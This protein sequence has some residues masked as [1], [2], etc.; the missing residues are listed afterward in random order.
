MKLLLEEISI[1]RINNIQ[2]GSIASRWKEFRYLSF[3]NNT[4]KTRKK[5]WT[6]PHYLLNIT[7]FEHN[8]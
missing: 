8:L 1:K 4:S 5:S 7:N 6:K 3:F 2:Q